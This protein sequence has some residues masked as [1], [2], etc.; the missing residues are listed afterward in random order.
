[1]RRESTRRGTKI[2]LATLLS[3]TLI[4]AACGGGSDGDSSDA[5][6]TN[7][8]E[9]TGDGDPEA[10]D[11]PATSANK[12]EEGTVEEDDD[13]IRGG[14]LRYGLEADVDGLNP[15][16]SGWSSPGLMMAN[17]VFDSVAAFDAEGK[18]VPYLAESIEPVGG[19]LTRWQVTL[20]PGITFHDGTPL[21]SEALQINFETQRADP[22]VGLA[23]RPIFPE[24]G[25]SEIIDDLT[26][27]YNLLEPWA[28]FA[29]SLASQVGYVASPT[30]LTAALKNPA[31]NQEPVGTGPFKFDSRSPDSVTRFVRNDDWWAGD[32]YLDAVEFVPV[33]DPDT[34]NDLLFKGDLQ[35]LQTS[36]PAS[37]IDLQDDPDIQ[38]IVDETG[39]EG[40]V[41]MNA[42]EAPFDDIR[43][44]KA[45]TFA[46]PLEN[47]RE[48]V[49]LGISRPADQMFIPESIYYNPDVVQEG[50]MPEVAVA[51]AAE[52]CADR[53]TEINPVTGEPTCTGGKINMEY[54]F[55]GPSVTATRIAEILDEGWSSAF[56]VTFDELAQDDHINQ[57][58]LGLYN[59]GIWRYFGST[60]PS[61][62]KVWL[63]CRTIG[64]ISL[65]FPRYCD[66]ERDDLI[67]EGQA[68]NDPA[69]RI[70]T[71]QEISQ[72][73]HDSYTYVFLTH[74]MWDNAF[75]PEVRGI[76]DQTSP[77]GT[78]LRCSGGGRTWFDAVWITG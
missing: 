25:A 64:F 17:A 13:P 76:C 36:N 19:D 73:L 50:D 53:G 63:M 30:W 6:S 7:A 72:K 51:L 74:T 58:A 27:Q 40:L 60:D 23:V 68:T 22:L 52:Y 48:L 42:E 77:D 34:R 39:D 15:T 49:G 78:L 46:T 32:A 70:P 29:A 2:G 4:A 47:I 16:S 61:T 26:L 55:A 9:G 12:V 11:A 5:E 3:F 8:V 57:V 44:R 35:A 41:I 45:L 1:M 14:T 38:N 59:A 10:N 69:V 56:N 65:N 20:R 18:P 43:A 67:I 37:I 66:E 54:Q 71:Y 21:N 24:V 33:T 31:L 62:D 28:Q 75:A